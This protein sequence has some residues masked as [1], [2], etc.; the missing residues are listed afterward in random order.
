MNAVRARR[1]CPVTYESPSANST[2]AGV[3]SICT[4]RSRWKRNCVDVAVAEERQRDRDD[5]RG[6]RDDAGGQRV[7]LAAP[8]AATTTAIGTSR[9]EEL[10]H[11]PERRAP[12]TPDAAGRARRAAARRATMSR[13]AAGRSACGRIA[14]IG[15]GE[16]RRPHQRSPRRPAEPARR[17]HCSASA[18]ASIEPRRTPTRRPPSAAAEHVRRA[19][20]GTTARAAGTRSAKSRY[21]TRAVGEQPGR[22]EPVEVEV[23]DGSTCRRAGRRS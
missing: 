5:D 18:H 8:D 23:V 10:R 12:R 1:A 17:P 20:I 6:E 16:E 14:P 19:T 21:G 2:I 4:G 3:D 11:R 22:Y 13:R 15:S 7:A 9:R